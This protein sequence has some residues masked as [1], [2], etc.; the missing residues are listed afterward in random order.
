MKKPLP[1]GR[2]QNGL[3]YSLDKVLLPAHDDKDSINKER[4]VTIASKGN[5]ENVKLLHLCLSHLPFSRTKMMYPTL[6]IK[7]VR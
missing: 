5:L 4:L 1:L 3:Y 7:V 6:D 2:L